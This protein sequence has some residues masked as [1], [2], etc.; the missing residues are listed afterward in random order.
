MI[1]LVIFLNGI[2]DLFCGFA[3]LFFSSNPYLAPIAN[4]HPKIFKEAYRDDLTRRLLAYWIITYGIIRVLIIIGDKNKII[5][6][7]IIIS[8]IIEILA[9]LNENYYHKTTYN[10]KVLWIVALSFIF[11]IGIWFNNSL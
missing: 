4:L 2:Y 3:I 8:Y 10:N 6:A 11:I 1:N 9:Y 7:L 5:I